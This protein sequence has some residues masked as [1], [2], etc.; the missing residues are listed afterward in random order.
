MGWKPQNH[1]LDP[2]CLPHVYGV[3]C[4]GGQIVPHVMT[5]HSTGLPGAAVPQIGKTEGVVLKCSAS[6]TSQ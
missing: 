5:C 6:R 4:K 1:R 2:P 3:I